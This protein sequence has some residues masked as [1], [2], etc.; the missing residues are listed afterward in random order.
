MFIPSEQVIIA[1][2]DTKTCFDIFK[3]FQNL[4]PNDTLKVETISIGARNLD[5]I[6]SENLYELYGDYLK[7]THE[8]AF[9]QSFKHLVGPKGKMKLYYVT[10]KEL[11]KILPGSNI[12]MFQYQS[13]Y[14]FSLIT[15]DGKI[16]TLVQAVK[17]IIEKNHHVFDMIYKLMLKD[18]IRF[19]F[20]DNDLLNSLVLKN[21]FIK[22]YNVHTRMWYQNFIEILLD[23]YNFIDLNDKDSK[24][25][26]DS[27]VMKLSDKLV[28]IIQKVDSRNILNTNQL[29]KF[30]KVDVLK[31][32]DLL[33]A[34]TGAKDIK[35]LQTINI[36][37]HK[38]FVKK[39]L[40]EFFKPIEKI[41]TNKILQPEVLL[42]NKEFESIIDVIQRSYTKT[43]DNIIDFSHY[44]KKTILQE[45]YH[46]HTIATNYYDFKEKEDD[47]LN[48]LS[49]N[50]I[51][52]GVSKRKHNRI[53][54]KRIRKVCTEISGITPGMVKH[55]GDMEEIE[56][57][58]EDGE[59]LKT[60]YTSPYVKKLFKDQVINQSKRFESVSDTLCRLIDE[61]VITPVTFTDNESF[62]LL[63]QNSDAFGYEKRIMG[64]YEGERNRIFLL[65]NN[66]SVGGLGSIPN[67]TVLSLI[68]HELMHYSYQNALKDYMYIFNDVVQD[69]YRTFFNKYFDGELPKN[70]IG[71]YVKSL[72][73]MEKHGESG[74]MINN[75]N[76][77]LSHAQENFDQ[78]KAFMNS[79]AF[80]KL[81]LYLA[82][83][84]DN[85]TGVRIANLSKTFFTES[86]LYAYTKTFSSMNKQIVERL[87][88]QNDKPHFASV[89][90]QEFIATSEVS[91]MLA[92]TLVKE[93][94]K[95]QISLD[96]NH[97]IAKMINSL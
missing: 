56:L 61:G 22:D 1:I 92:G 68:L 12:S 91:A 66:V 19:V 83:G 24:D 65:I 79:K 13:S 25:R 73:K 20:K 64:F 43:F 8:K 23:K 62:N 52:E 76:N 31:E 33:D 30:F 40:Q 74:E 53:Y 69:F 67:S 27:I 57:A 97:P 77:I 82:K 72:Y 89:F 4:N 93:I 58:G 95:Q 11:L 51:F 48:L 28:D 36:Y 15:E 80:E 44:T 59:L 42:A 71:S 60:G 94:F 14:L 54:V 35:K 3:E 96:E 63:V 50:T 2:E 26:K 81:F 34:L 17:P 46:Y 16:I 70:L 84:T 75:L 55:S 9:N 10:P 90:Y 41:F 86:M 21:E 39:Y 37:E 29:I 38:K 5:V 49:K 87:K 32:N 18:V 88:V 7:E 6:H 45:L 47:L 78:E 85:N